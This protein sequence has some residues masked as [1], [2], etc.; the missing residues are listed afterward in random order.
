[1]AS[2]DD[3]ISYKEIP[4]DL[5]NFVLNTK[6]AKQD[7]NLTEWRVA[8]TMF[9]VPDILKAEPGLAH[10]TAYPDPDGVFRTNLVSVNVGDGIYMPSIGVSAF[11]YF[12]GE[13]TDLEID[14]NGAAILKT[15]KGRME[16][17]ITG[18]SGIRWAGSQKSYGYVS[19]KDLLASDG[20]DPAMKK[21]LEGKIVF[22]GSTAM[23]PT[24]ATLLSTPLF[25]G[26]TPT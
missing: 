25:L 3:D 24:Y 22:I 7:V 23:G 10:I 12:T 13:N 1:M 8:N 14:S 19:I 5:Y 17:D 26:F 11:Q 16:L 2:T 15:K 21:E 4:G 20:K 9:P 18:A 6:Q